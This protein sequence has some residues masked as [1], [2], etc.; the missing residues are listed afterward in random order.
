MIGLGRRGI[1]ESYDERVPDGIAEVVSVCRVARWVTSMSLKKKATHCKLETSTY[2]VTS[3]SLTRGK[4]THGLG[5]SVSSVSDA[6]TACA[7]L[8][9]LIF[10]SRGRHGP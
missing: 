1:A 10:V 4:S 2:T 3:N 6:G 9:Q 5:L 8:H 7:A